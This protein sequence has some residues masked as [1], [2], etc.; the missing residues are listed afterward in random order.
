MN[1]ALIVVD[2]I[3]EFV[4]GRLGSERAEAVVPGCERMLAHARR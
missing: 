2:M 3:E 4:T 1:T